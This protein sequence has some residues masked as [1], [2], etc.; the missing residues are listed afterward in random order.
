MRILLDENL[1]WRL[2]RDLPMHEVD[3]VPLIGWAG[4]DNGELL[5]KAAAAGYDVLVT[6]DTNMTHHQNVRRF[7]IAVVALR[8]KSNRLAETRPLMPAL[9][10]LLPALEPR[11]LTFVPR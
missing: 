8:A 9:L 2:R 3:S 11:T 6:M 10:E 1:D 5:S 4:I 7:A